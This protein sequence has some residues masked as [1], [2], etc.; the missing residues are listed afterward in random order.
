[1]E[2]NSLE[3]HPV[4]LINTSYANKDKIFTDPTVGKFN[5]YRSSTVLKETLN[6]TETV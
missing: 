3:I 6:N 2:F 5:C 4:M 1:M